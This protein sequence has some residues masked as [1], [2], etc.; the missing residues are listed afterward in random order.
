[1]PE[2]D[3]Y[4]DRNI[5]RAEQMYGRGFQTP[6]G[7]AAVERACARLDLHPGTRVLDVGSGLGGPAMHL[8][9]AYGATVVGVD[10]AEAMHR[11]SSERAREAGVPGVSFLLGDVRTLAL[12]PDS[13]DVVWTRDAILYVQDKEAIWSCLAELL[14]PGGQLY[15]ADFCRGQAD[16]SP[17]FESYIA[18]AGYYLQ[19]IPA[20]AA[21]L[22]GCGFA[23]VQ[24][25][26]E[27]E[28]FAGSLVAEL[29]HLESTKQALLAAFSREDYEYLVDRWRKKIELSRRGELRWGAFLAR[30]ASA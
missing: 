17:D 22:A 18:N 1:M 3:R 20:Y 13:F 7:L 9:A 6:G 29:E 10:T 27:T 21:T 11:L 25:S 15:V 30:R 4:T 23:D 2:T 8:A 26:D 28:A 14:R 16:G 24:P 12:E 5:L 19:T